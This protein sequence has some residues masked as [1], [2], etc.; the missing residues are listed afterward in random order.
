VSNGL[1]TRPG[2][3][4]LGL[5]DL[6]EFAWTGHIRVPHFQRDFKWVKQDVIRLF[7]SILRRYPIGS[8]LLWRRSAPRQRFVLGA[9]EIEAPD[10]DQA[11]WVVDGQQRITSLANV[12]HPKGVGDPRFS[13]GYDL[14]VGQIVSLPQGEDPFIVPLSVVFDLAKV[15]TWFADHPEATEHQGRAFELAKHLREFNMPAYLVEQEDVQVLQDIFDRMNNYGKRLSRAE[16]FSALNAGPES[17]MNDRLTI[18]RITEHIDD[19]YD[20]GEIDADT[21]LR[22]ILARR[23]PNIQREIRLEFDVGNRRGVPEFQ[24][25]EWTTA[26]TAG[27]VALGRAVKFLTKIGV[28]HFTLLPYKYLLIVLTRVFAHHPDPDPAS[29]RLLSRWFWRAALLGPEIFKGSATGAAQALCGRVYPDDLSTSVR[30]LLAALDRPRP[31][32]PELRRFRTNEAATKIVICSWWNQCPRHPT[33]GTPYER[34]QLAE[35]LTDRP[36]AADAVHRL[37]SRRLIP[38]KY[39]LWAANRVFMPVLDEPTSNARDILLNRPLD[40]DEQQWRT[41]LRSHAIT[42]EI[43]GLLASADVEQLLIARQAELAQV[44]D[45]FLGRKCEWR[46]EDTPPLDELVIEDL[47]GEEGNDAV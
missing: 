28:P 25:E 8:L 18:D 29:R 1:E 39:R 37:I 27:E 6:V 36:T 7:D 20:F 47:P 19:Q 32:P 14:R 40:L 5:D 38:Q 33:S 34:G 9:I 11:L 23:G 41:V 13:L 12:L 2:A 22:A 26:F 15:L 30:D 44:L 16:V 21:V 46:F 24:D 45:T 17:G 43:E 31:A 42:P 10:I 3:T 35:V 4:T